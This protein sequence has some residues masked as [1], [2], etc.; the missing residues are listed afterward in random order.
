[1]KIRSAFLLVLFLVGCAA[2]PPQSEVSGRLGPAGY[3]LTEHA[4][5]RPYDVPLDKGFT[6]DPDS[7]LELR[8][9]A[10]M[11]KAL[12]ADDPRWV[13]V[14]AWLDDTRWFS[15][16]LLELNRRK[17]DERNVQALRQLQ[18]DVVGFNT[19]VATQIASSN[20]IL[21]DSG[22]NAAQIGS[23]QR[24]TFDNKPGDAISN[25]TRWIIRQREELLAEARS[26][27]PREGDQ[28]VVM[29]FHKVAG[30]TR[31]RL[32]VEHYDTISSGMDLALKRTALGLT[33]RELSELNMQIEQSERAVRVI[34]QLQTDRD[35]LK[36]LH[37]QIYD[38]LKEKLA[39]LQRLVET[40]TSTIR[41]QLE[42]ALGRAK[43]VQAG[44]ASGTA[45][46]AQVDS[47]VKEIDSFKKEWEAV[48]MMKASIEKI[49]KAPQDGDLPKFLEEIS[50]A[51]GVVSNWPDRIA[52]I[53]TQANELATAL[54]AAS[55]QD[56]LSVDFK[57]ESEKILAAVEP[58]RT[59]IGQLLAHKDV[60]RRINMLASAG[61]ETVPRKLD[62]L[63]PARIDLR[64][65]RF[66]EGDGVTIRLELHESTET[67]KTDRPK[68]LIEYHLNVH[69][70][71]W[72]RR[73]SG[74]PIFAR[75]SSGTED[76]KKW[77][78]NVGVTATWYYRER[79]PN[80]FGKLINQLE[81]GIG[82]HAASLDQTDE[83]VEFGFGV[84]IS[85]W[86]GLLT[87]GAGKNLSTA[88]DNTYF[89]L[90]SDLF[91]LLGSLEPNK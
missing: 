35:A 1:M 11:P 66:D 14:N 37:K 5:D 82:I 26:K 17:V 23:V 58:V 56:I 54:R 3:K 28:V 60:D 41:A 6:V 44:T 88:R 12:A 34:R 77:K 16:K 18:G 90:G 72:Y 4:H 15:A 2:Q 68:Q 36:Q 53:Q 81:P 63:L 50:K 30:Q 83:S 69:E 89:L 52:K 64:G 46:R 67:L 22:L 7:S 9:D 49:Q 51:I 47:L 85:F 33:E 86:K 57:K 45:I 42:S 61:D 91:R 32:H 80:R 65:Y 79:F 19:Q 43:T 27:Q 87:L 24:G 29:A 8:F 25:M 55:L 59:Y 40:A 38:K 71:D 75:A 78:P 76:A 31:E 20:K 70:Q 21:K 39:E 74:I 73:I 10:G 13:A 84:N 48:T 62:E